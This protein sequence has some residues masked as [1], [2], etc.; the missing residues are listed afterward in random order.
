MHTIARWPYGISIHMLPEVQ[1]FE[2]SVDRSSIGVHC[3]TSKVGIGPRKK[4]YKYYSGTLH[5]SSG[6]AVDARCPSTTFY[7]RCWCLD[8]ISGCTEPGMVMIGCGSCFR[9]LTDMI[10]PEIPLGPG[11][12]P[13]SSSQCLEVPH[14]W[15]HKSAGLLRRFDR[16]GFFVWTT[17]GMLLLTHI[18]YHMA[19]F[20]L[21]SAIAA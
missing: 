19:P 16:S 11:L 20:W 3:V 7:A 8:C 4:R 21:V 14:R 18:R 12:V 2:H 10:C 13:T 9:V 17:I 6:K 1:V 5:V 15:S